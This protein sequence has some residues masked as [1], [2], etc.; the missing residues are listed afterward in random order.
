MQ[1]TESL[2]RKIDGIL[3]GYVLSLLRAN[4]I[5][6]RK[7]REFSLE[8]IPKDDPRLTIHNDVLFNFLEVDLERIRRIEEKARSSLLGISVATAILSAAT[9][10]LARS[11]IYGRGIGPLEYAA[12]MVVAIAFSFA[13]ASVLLALR[14]YSISP[15]SRPQMDDY[16]ESIGKRALLLCIEKNRL[17]ATTKSNY[18]TG[19]LNCMRNGIFTMAV[20]GVLCV[21]VF[22]QF[23]IESSSDSMQQT[24]DKV[25]DEVDSVLAKGAY[26]EQSSGSRTPFPSLP[27]LSSHS[28]GD[29]EMTADVGQ[30]ESHT[31]ANG[32]IVHLVK[33][34]EAKWQIRFYECRHRVRI[35][36]AGGMVFEYLEGLPE[37]WKSREFDSAD[38]A[39]AFVQEE[40][41]QGKVPRNSKQ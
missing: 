21:V 35:A 20:A 32:E 16:L 11:D 31:L 30:N 14:A 7:W 23:N 15:I 41:T 18:L 6:Q 28:E 8:K 33:H 24:G 29:D 25:I 38:A 12:G 3:T 19:C 27:V 1:I 5:V 26:P 10:L 17:T 40:I 37:D 34:P 22:L 2:T 4:R 36:G 13:I 9:A 39:T